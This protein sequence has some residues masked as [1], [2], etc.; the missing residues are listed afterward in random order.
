VVRTGPARVWASR[1]LVVLAGRVVP[2][3][4]PNPQVI[5][6]V[7]PRKV[8][9]AAW[10]RRMRRVCQSGQ[11]RGEHQPEPDGFLNHLHDDHFG[12][13]PLIFAVRRAATCRI[14]CLVTTLGP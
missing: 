12:R 1:S 4:R 2:A 13:Q 3:P 8:I 14:I 5:P 11:R 9:N 6:N 10:R 7:T